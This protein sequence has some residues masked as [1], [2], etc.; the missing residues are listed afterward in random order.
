MMRE[1]YFAKLITF[2]PVAEFLIKANGGIPG[3]HGNAA[4]ALVPCYILSK[5]NNGCADSSAVQLGCNS[6][7]PEAHCIYIY[8]SKNAATQHIVVIRAYNKDIIH[9]FYEI[10]VAEGEPE[11]PAQLCIPQLNHLQVF[12]RSVVYLL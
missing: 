1:R 12:I 6:H 11:G 8:M 3:M 5:A 2:D 9:F 4:V 10:I 7:L